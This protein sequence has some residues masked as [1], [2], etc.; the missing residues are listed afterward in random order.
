MIIQTRKKQYIYLLLCPYPS[1]FVMFDDFGHRFEWKNSLLLK[2]PIIYGFL[3]TFFHLHCSQQLPPV[4]ENM[5]RPSSF[6]NSVSQ[7]SSIC[8][9]VTLLRGSITSFCVMMMM[10][11]NTTEALVKKKPNSYL[12]IQL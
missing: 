1:L 12:K 4:V 2:F 8:P 5:L 11:T 3:M 9:S 7:Y 10:K 6:S